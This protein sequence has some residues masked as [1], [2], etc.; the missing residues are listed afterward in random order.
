MSDNVAA[1]PALG[2][3]LLFDYLYWLRDRVLRVAGGLTDAA[4]L[5]T[6]SS[7][8]RDLRATLAHELDV[9]MS[10]RAR[11]RGRAEK[12]W[13]PEAEI[14]PHRFASVADLDAMWRE[15][16]AVMRDWLRNLAPSDLERPVTT[17]RLEGYALSVYL[18]HVV[19][20]GVTELASAAGILHGMGHSA[21]DLGV[22]DALDDLAPM[23]R[24]DPA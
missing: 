7:H 21:G 9:E 24:H 23:P 18:L 8:G 22:L 4:F 12:E 19:E 11:L 16:E 10:W 17:N 6:P 15:D 14:E 3:P 13:G 1:P 20:H 5:E 2:I